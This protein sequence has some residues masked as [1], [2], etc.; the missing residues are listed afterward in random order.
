MSK[1]KRLE[2]VIVLAPLY[3]SVNQAWMDN[4]LKQLVSYKIGAVVVS[5]KNAEK[6]LDQDQVFRT[7]NFFPIS[8]RSIFSIVKSCVLNPGLIKDIRAALKFGV[9]SIDI[10]KVFIWLRLVGFLR[11]PM[12]ERLLIHSHSET[13]SL[14]FVYFASANDIPFVLTFHGF[15]PTGVS[16]LSN[17]RRQELYRRCAKIIVNTEYAKGVV[18]KLGAATSKVMVLPQGIPIERFEFRPLPPMIKGRLLR[19]LTVGRIHKEKGLQYA[20][21]SAARLRLA[22]VN[23]VWTFVGEGDHSKRFVKLVQKLGLNDYVK[24]IP[25]VPNIELAG[26]YQYN[27]LF[28]L[29]STSSKKGCDETQG[30]VLQEAQACGCI[31]IATKIGGIPEVIES[32]VDGILIP[33]RSS[34]VLTRSIQ[35]L[36]NNSQIWE[37]YRINGRRKIE[38]HFSSDVIGQRMTKA[39]NQVLEDFHNKV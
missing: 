5:G 3:P 15:R 20:L 31:P 19:I 37:T 32:G 16:Q 11:L 8:N 23:F 38:E 26:V 39:L 6:K 9:V 22:G 14:P 13:F 10:L 33:E 29:P 7:V 24:L 1:L 25:Q 28:V 21:V 35:Y 34:K 2:Q 17:D 30:V 4:Y 12:S 36:L 27:H 18:C